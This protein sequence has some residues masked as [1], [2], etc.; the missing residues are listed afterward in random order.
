MPGQR[1]QALASSQYALHAPYYATWVAQFY[2]SR[3][4]AFYSAVLL[5]V[6][7]RLGSN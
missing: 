7:S 1:D 3:P 5:L 2:V 4:A 6:R